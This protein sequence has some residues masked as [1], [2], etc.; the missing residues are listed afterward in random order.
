MQNSETSLID[1]ILV[2]KCE[3]DRLVD[4][5]TLYMNRRVSV[6]IF[7]HSLTLYNVKKQESLLN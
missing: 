4:V 5:N 3:N 1:S 2:N 7:S 6:I